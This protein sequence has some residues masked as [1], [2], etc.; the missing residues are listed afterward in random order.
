MFNFLIP[1]GLRGQERLLLMEAP[2]HLMQLLL[3]VAQIRFPCS[4]MVLTGR[5]DKLNLVDG[6]L[7]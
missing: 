1:L 3:A 2:P 4:V 7:K 5:L 6:E